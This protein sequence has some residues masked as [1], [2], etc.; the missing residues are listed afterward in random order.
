MY[1]HFDLIPKYFPELT[2][3][4]RQRLLLLW[5]FYHDWNAKINV[6]SRKDIDELYL[7]HVLHSL[8]IAK[9]F[10]F[11]GHT[12]ILDIGTGGGFPGIPLSILFENTRITMVDSI[13]KKIRVVQEAI[14]LLQLTNASTHQGR[15]EDMDERYDFVVCRAVADIAE[16]VGW[17]KNILRTGT[18]PA[19]ERGLLCLKGGDLGEELSQVAWKKMA[20]DLHTVFNEDYFETKRLVHLMKK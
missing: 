11:D 7:R 9:F 19:G 2:D 6:I 5:D 1:P 10:Q 13:G 4:Q 15:A 18:T 16:L 20:Y 8:S 3:R 14:Q 17:T 12:T